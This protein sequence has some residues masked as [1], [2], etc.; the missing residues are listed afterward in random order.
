MTF[1]VRLPV[2]GYVYYRVSL[3]SAHLSILT[4]G[5]RDFYS[6]QNFLGTPFLPYGQK[7]STPALTL[8][9]LLGLG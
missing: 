2:A 5:G 6:H 1:F 9:G 4:P 8:R 3:H 7:C